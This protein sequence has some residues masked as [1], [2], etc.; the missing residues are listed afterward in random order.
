MKTIQK[1]KM[2]KLILVRMI[3]TLAHSKIF[4]NKDKFNGCSEYGILRPVKGFYLL[5]IN[6]EY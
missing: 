4:F 6:F 1:Q 3:I 2:I 5:N